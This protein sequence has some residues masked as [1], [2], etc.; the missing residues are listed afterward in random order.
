MPTGTTDSASN[1]KPESESPRPAVP[2]APLSRMI[3]REN[4]LWLLASLVLVALAGGLVLVDWPQIGDQSLSEKILPVGLVLLV[5]LFGAYAWSKSKEM[6]E[7]HTLVRG[8]EQRTTATPEVGQLEKLFELVE[9]SQRG[10]RDLIDT[11]NDLLFSISLDGRIMAANRSFADLVGQPFADLVGRPLDEFFDPMDGG[12]AAAEKALPRF[13]ERRHWSGVIARETRSATPPRDS[14]NATC[15]RWS[16]T[17]RIRE[18]VS[19]RMT[20]PG[21][22]KMKLAS[23]SCSR[24]SR[25]ASTWQRP[26]G[27]LKA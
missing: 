21:T 1:A 27:A 18:S 4:R 17:A 23:P 13:L 25:K 20:L 14:C 5:C 9:R 6:A 22:A 19:W 2:A 11:F 7:L 12:R 24:P 16:G 26:T 10:Y 8:L 15:M 3:D